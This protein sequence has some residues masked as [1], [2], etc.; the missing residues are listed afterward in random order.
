MRKQ[1]L[2]LQREWDALLTVATGGSSPLVKR[3]TTAVPVPPSPQPSDSLLSSPNA[4]N[5]KANAELLQEVFRVVYVREP[6]NRTEF[7]S[8]VDS[9]N[10]GAS[11]EGVYNG[12]S[13]SSAYRGLE[14]A[15]V[16]ASPEALKAFGEELAVLEVELPA[17]AEFDHAAT[18]PLAM[19]V[20][21]G[22]EGVGP[23]SPAKGSG[24]AV[25]EYGKP[26]ASSAP[27][28]VAQ[29]AARYSQQFM[30]SSIYTLKRV[31][32]DE[33]LKVI[34]LK[35]EYPE[36][37]AQWYSKWAGRMATRKVD[38]GIALR[39]SPDEAFHYQWAIHATEDRIKWE[40]LNRLHRVLN[41]ANRAK[42]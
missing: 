9:L 36:K 21:P 42:Q 24:V 41:D 20:Q 30:G 5:A 40:V 7:G 27:L 22:A 29:L 23:D 28:G 2:R 37:L 25:I 26:V 12:F 4:R 14:I 38:F 16:G 35:H 18:R 13:H 31:L 17:P 32:G 19:P 15:T 1:W 39:N 34:T 33:A 3:P 6:T 8:M 11:F 10:Q